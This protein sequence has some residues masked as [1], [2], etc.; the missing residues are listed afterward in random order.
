MAMAATQIDLEP[1]QRALAGLLRLH[2]SRRVFAERAAAAGVVVSQ[3]AGDLLSRIDD[4]GPLI[5]GELGRLAH[6]DPS[7]VGRQV[8]QLEVQGLVVRAPDPDDGRVTRV[9]ATPTGRALRRRLDEAGRRHLADT[10]A[11][12]PA[13]DRR[14]LARLLPKLVADLRERSYP[15]IPPEDRRSA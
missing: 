1:V 12:W 11:D 9:T 15:S 4:D 3:P 13:E 7:A 5:L 8:R 6:M 2:A 10:L 14:E